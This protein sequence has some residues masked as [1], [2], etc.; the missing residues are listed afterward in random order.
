MLICDERGELSIGEIG[1]TCDVVKYTD[2]AIALEIGVRALRPDVIITDELSVQD[3]EWIEKAVFAGIKIIAS[4][5]FS[6]MTYVK[7][8]FL[9]IFDRYAFL[10]DEIGHLARICD[11]T[12]RDVAKC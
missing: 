3:C 10:K 11:E 9:G 8:P 6:D 5:H 2:K 1:K 4:A 7:S 12:G